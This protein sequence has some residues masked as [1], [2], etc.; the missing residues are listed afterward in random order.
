MN[1]FY[2]KNKKN[3][4]ILVYL[5]Q[6]NFFNKKVFE[7]YDDFFIKNLISIFKE[8]SSTLI[9]LITGLIKPT[10]GIIKVDNKK[11]DNNELSW[12]QNIAYVSQK[13]YVIDASILENIAFGV[14]KEKIDLNL[15][16]KCS[17]IAELT[18]FIKSR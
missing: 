10:K 9:D 7:N 8:R 2:L 5:N 1:N 3:D 18:K 11:I 16:K 6:S 17:D 14:N 15:V 13:A 12:Q 4:E